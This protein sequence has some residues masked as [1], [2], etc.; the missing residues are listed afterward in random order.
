MAFAILLAL[1][2]AVF[3]LYT[4]V[5]RVMSPTTETTL[6][7]YLGVTGTVATLNTSTTGAATPTT[8]GNATG[9]ILVRP[10]AATASSSLK[11][12][13]ITDFRPTNLLD[14]DLGSAWVEGADGPGLGEWVRL[15]FESPILIDRIEI[16]NG[17][18]RDAERFQ[19]NERIENIQLQYSDGTSQVVKLLDAEGL[20][21]IEPEVEDTQWI[22][23]TILSVYPD[24]KWED[25]ALSDVRIYES[26]Q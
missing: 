2:V 23:V 12:T 8:G 16:A 11:S 15:D 20:Q 13:S 6:N 9:S 5:T 18:Q 19:G 10:S 25:A 7:P 3:V 1:A 17:Y 26:I 21:L 4:I 14:G 22:K 24:Y